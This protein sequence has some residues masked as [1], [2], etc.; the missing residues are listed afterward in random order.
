MKTNFDIQ[1]S[2]FNTNGY[3]PNPKLLPI[4]DLPISIIDEL[5]NMA[6]N[7]HE[8]WATQK[9]EEGWTFGET[10][11]LMAKKHPSLK[12]Y[13][14]LDETQKN[15]DRNTALATLTYLIENGYQ[16]VKKI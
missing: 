1:I 10:L 6:E 11:D 16:I 8:V 4:K 2:G 9:M 12:P 14:E 15:Y 7:I 13:A 3:V 5:E